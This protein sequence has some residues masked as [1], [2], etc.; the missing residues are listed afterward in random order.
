M[1]CKWKKEHL[2]VVWVGLPTFI[3]TSS[4]FRNRSICAALSS[5]FREFC[6][7]SFSFSSRATLWMV[8]SSSL[9]THR[10]CVPQ[11]ASTAGRHGTILT[12]E[13]FSPS[14]VSSWRCWTSQPPRRRSLCPVWLCNLP[15]IRQGRNC[16]SAFPKPKISARLTVWTWPRPSVCCS[17]SPAPL[18]PAAAEKRAAWWYSASFQFPCYSSTAHPASVWSPRWWNSFLWW[19]ACVVQ[20]SG[21]IKSV[22]CDFAWPG[23]VNMGRCKCVMDVCVCVQHFFTTAQVWLSVSCCFICVTMFSHHCVSWFVSRMVWCTSSVVL[24]VAAWKENNVFTDTVTVRVLVQKEKLIKLLQNC[25]TVYLSS[26]AFMHPS[27]HLRLWVFSYTTCMDWVSVH[28][29]LSAFSFC[30]AS[31]FFF[32][33]VRVSDCKKTG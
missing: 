8:T 27:Q 1:I 29:L 24:S 16:P 31:W 28:S 14:L 11:R 17:S 10:A 3:A 4:S 7:N 32:S 21:W 9:Q 25:S 19:S 12:S 2:Y 26:T 22:K 18:R 15:S 6:V 23:K 30:L 13:C 5:S 20:V 33:I